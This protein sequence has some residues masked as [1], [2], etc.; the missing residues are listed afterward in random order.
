MAEMV[1]GQPGP[2]TFSQQQELRVA[3]DARSLT[4]TARRIQR[5]PPEFDGTLDA[6]IEQYVLGVLPT[7]ESVRDFHEG[8]QTYINSTNPLF[9]LRHVSGTEGREIY[10]TNDGTRFRATDNSPAWWVHAALM[11]RYRIAPDAF[12]EVVATMSTHM[13]SRR[14]LLRQLVRP[15]GT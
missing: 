15:V 6:F 14:I 13:M 5:S 12:A 3:R 4:V 2:L 10:H 7:R 9:L 8:L 11:Q 1:S